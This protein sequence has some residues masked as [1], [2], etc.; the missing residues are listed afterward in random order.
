MMDEDREGAAGSAGLSIRVDHS[1]LVDVGA[2]TM[3][4]KAVPEVGL[5]AEG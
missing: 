5:D 1:A 4:T 2:M 3:L